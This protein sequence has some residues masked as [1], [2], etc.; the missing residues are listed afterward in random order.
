MKKEELIKRLERVELPDMQVL[1]HKQRL[2]QVL[3][4]SAVPGHLT[5]KKAF[6]DERRSGFGAFL[7]WLRGPAWRPAVASALSVIVLGAILASVFYVVAPSPS[8]IAADVVKKDPSIQQKLSGNGEIIIVRVEVQDRIA[9]VVCGRGMGDFIE[10]DVDIS[11]RTVVTTRRF[12]GLFM[13]ELAPE[14]HENAINIA[15]LDPRIKPL[16]SKCATVGRVFPVFSGISSIAISNNNIV[17]VTPSAYHAIVPI[18]VDGKA[19]LV[20]VNLDEKKIDRIIEPQSMFMPYFREIYTTV[21]D[22]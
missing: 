8:V 4:E 7:D 13:A 11:G 2:K 6:R 16:L 9:R 1:G 17:K 18:Y 15:L 5:L 12:E 19:W 3:I 20:D 21:T 14:A 22:I 10:A